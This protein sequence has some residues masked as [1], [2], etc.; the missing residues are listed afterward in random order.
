MTEKSD[1]ARFCSRIG[2][3]P[4]SQEIAVSKGAIRLNKLD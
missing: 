3:S 2:E 4:N 1:C